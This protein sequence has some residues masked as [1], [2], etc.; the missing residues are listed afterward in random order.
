MTGFASTVGANRYTA[1]APQEYQIP[2]NWQGKF[3][4]LKIQQFS[5]FIDEQS[6]LEKLLSVE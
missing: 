4:S 3:N 1:V 2:F 5:T 6:E